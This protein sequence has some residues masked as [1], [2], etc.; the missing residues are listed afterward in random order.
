MHDVPWPARSAGQA[1]GSLMT[2]PDGCTWPRCGR[3]VAIVARNGRAYCKAHADRLPPHLRREAGNIHRRG[4][5][6]PR[7]VS[8]ERRT[9]L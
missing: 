9:A 6:R 5:D 3:R 2:E 1:K 4:R 7:R 8:E